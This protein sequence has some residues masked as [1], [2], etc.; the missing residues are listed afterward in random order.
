LDATIDSSVACSPS[1]PDAIDGEGVDANCD[2]VDGVLGEV[3]FVAVGG[4]DSNTGLVPTSPVATLARAFDV[5]RTNLLATVLMGAGAYTESAAVDL[6]QVRTI[7]GGYDATWRGTRGLSTVACAEALRIR[8]GAA[9]VLERVA[10]NVEGVDEG[11]AFGAIVD[12]DAILELIDGEIAVGDGAGGLS[13]VALPPIAPAAAGLTG[14]TC[15]RT[16]ATGPCIAGAAP[17]RD[18]PI[19]TCGAVT[20]GGAGGGTSA[21][22]GAGAG[23][24]TAGGS[25][26]GLSRAGEGESGTS[27]AS[28][29]N[30]T[31]PAAPGRVT[32]G[33]TPTY[34]RPLGGD[35][36][37]G[38]AGS[39][40]GGGGGDSAEYE[41]VGSCAGYQL[42]TFTP[43]GA[44]GGS[45]GLGGCS[46]TG[47][48][49]GHSGGA[50][51]AL[52][53]A[54]GSRVTLVRSTLRT[55]LGG[56]GGAGR[57][58]TI[59]GAGGGGGPGGA[60]A[61]QAF[62]S[63]GRYIGLP[64]APGGRGGNGGAGG[65][66]AGGSGGPSVAIWLIGDASADIATAMIIRGRGGEPGPSDGV[67]G[68]AGLSVDVYEER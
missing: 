46:G 55:G 32:L 30:G 21:A 50:S 18:P 64:G 13:G 12:E 51:I 9:R 38:Q 62:A 3:V 37:S 43:R 2:G 24:L 14:N 25:A 61:C 65:H 19:A 66:G 52:V 53:A 40:G 54:A 59:G 39:G 45:G 31:R 60:P 5:A 57:S 34:A 23:G 1:A 27:G 22:G 67:P 7:A 41:I 26:G 68:E 63:G 33:A 4:D 47:G 35:G 8:A 49:G 36:G 28:G 17:R 11:S 10:F 42:V 58:G 16:I 56:D 29:A 20:A 6:D 44:G 48:R 15:P